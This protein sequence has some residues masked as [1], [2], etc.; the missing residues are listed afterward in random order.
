MR[1]VPVHLDR[2]GTLE[3][4]RRALE[5]EHHDLLL[6]DVRIGGGRGIELVEAAGAAG[7]PSAAIVLVPVG[8]RAGADAARQAGAAEVL[9]DDELDPEMLERSIRHG[10]ERARLLAALRD[11]EEGYRLLLEGSRDGLWDWDL[12]EHRIVFGPRWKALLGEEE[13]AVG[14]DPEEWFGRVHPGDRARLRSAIRD[15]LEGRTERLEVEHRIRHADGRYRTVLARGVAARDGSGRAHRLAG[16]LTDV[17]PVREAEEALAYV[18]FHD[19]VTDLPN[20][21]LFMDRLHAAVGDASGRAEGRCA[22]LLVDLRRRHVVDETLG[23]RAGDR[24]LAEAARRLRAVAGSGEIVARLGGDVFAVLLED[25]DLVAA[26]TVAG[27]IQAAFDPPFDLEGGPVYATPAIGIAVATGAETP[28][29]LL[30]DAQAAMNRAG[31]RGGVVRFDERMRALA[32][33]E[34]RMEAELRRALD[35]EELRVYYQPV[36]RLATGRVGA[37]EALV[38]WEHPEQGLLAPDEFLPAA[39]AAGLLGAI[40]LWVLRHACARLAAWRRASSAAAEVAIGVNLSP[41]HLGEEGFVD[42]VAEVLA[43]TGLDPARLQLEITETALVEDTKAVVTT[44]ERLRALRVSV[45]LDDFGT[46]YSSLAYLQRLP[47]DAFKMDRSFLRTAAQ[48][49]AGGGLVRTILAL[50]RDLALPVIAEGVE[51]TADLATLRE[52]GCDFGQGFLFSE[53]VPADEAF[54]LLTRRPVW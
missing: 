39:E 44:L 36:V 41:E 38:R 5:E 45:C 7:T 11:R 20:R 54:A 42:T 47:V 8:D 30:R 9:T 31:L 27:R 33:A 43:E 14:D 32:T 24:L 2:V 15:H 48:V 6:V 16:S 52:L 51:T 3:A 50:G 18:S 23:H 29:G 19:E 34:F 22:V 10:R 46:G 17:T 21:V 1:S 26:T 40:D 4:A 28:G 37:F 12:R 49:P 13:A 53:P 25:A 35:E